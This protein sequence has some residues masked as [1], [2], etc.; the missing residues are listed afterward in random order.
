[1]ALQIEQLK[2][3]HPQ[4]RVLDVGC[5]NGVF[6]WLAGKT[7]WKAEGIDISAFAVQWGIKQF[8]VNLRLS[9]LDQ[10][11]E[12]ETYDLLSFW[13][14]LEH[15]RDPFAALRHAHRR[16][17][18]GG[19]LL[20]STPDQGSLVNLVV[21]FIHR[22]T[23]GASHPL[24]RRLYH[25]DHI[26]FFNRQ[27]LTRLLERAGLEVVSIEGY[28]EAPEDTETGGLLRTAVAVVQVLARCCGREHQMLLL[29]R[30]R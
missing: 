7:G 27:T 16:L 10:V 19:H 6:V 14:T 4:A 26:Y 24:T 20:I 12:T 8:G 1:M 11:E 18:P 9:R 21:N 28:D 5:S 17:R 13:N 3:L 15:M 25:P 29:A 22:L 30:R 2:K 23:F